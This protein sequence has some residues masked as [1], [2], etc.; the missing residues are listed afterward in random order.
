MLVIVRQKLRK[1]KAG[2]VV[3]YGNSVPKVMVLAEKI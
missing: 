2:K 3:V 1:Y